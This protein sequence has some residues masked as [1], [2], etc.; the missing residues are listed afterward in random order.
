MKNIIRYLAPIFGL[1]VA[2]PVARLAAADHPAPK[3]EKKEVRVI[4]GDDG[5]GSGRS[6]AKGVI[7]NHLG[8]SGEKEIV[9]YLGV[10][11][12]PVSPALT[13]QLGLPAH[14][15]LV[16]GRVAPGSPAASAL[17]EHDILLKLD[18][19]LL[20]DQHQLAVLVRNHQEGDE[21]TLTVVRGGKQTTAKVKL[22]KH[23]VPKM[24]MMPPGQPGAGFNGFGGGFGPGGGGNFEVFSGGPDNPQHREAIERMLPMLNDHNSAPGIR[25]LNILRPAGPGDRSVSVTVNT[26]NRHIVL[27]DDKGSLEL[28]MKEGRKELVAK[29]QQGEQIFAGPINTPEERKA[30]PPEVR[31]RLEKLEDSSQFSFKPDGDFKSESKVM[32]PRGTG[33]AVPPQ[34]ADLPRPSPLFF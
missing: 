7:I 24:A 3:Q 1:T 8:A 6:R 5:A 22:A 19:Q 26:A 30:L 25:R 16:V 27:D 13:A 21:V 23:E 28:T 14:A 32:R 15:G 4:V 9:T 10:E 33:I 17:K 20:V 29:N 12:A 11:T 31:G 34:P 18:D 2:W